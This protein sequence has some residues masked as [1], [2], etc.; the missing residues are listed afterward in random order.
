M[1]VVAARLVREFRI[2]LL[3]PVFSAPLGL[4]Y[5]GRMIYSDQRLP[6]FWRKRGLW[7][8]SC[9]S[10]FLG[11]IDSF[12]HS[13]AAILIQL[14]GLGLLILGIMDSSFLFMPLSND[15]L[16][17]AMTA[18]AHSL[19]PYYAAMASAGS[20]IGC[21]LVDLVF[22][23]GGE[24][25][26]QKHVSERRLAYVRDRVNKRAGWALLFATLMPP[27]FPFTPFIAVTAATEYPRKKMLTIVGAARMVRFSL[28][29]LLG[30]FFGAGIMSLIQST[31]FEYAV[32][33][34]I[35]VSIGGSIV[36]ILRWIRKSKREAPDTSRAQRR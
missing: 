18:R 17:I 10:A 28:E 3:G 16:V 27:P 21:L 29:G 20:V 15:L 25:M 6:E 13:A 7:G 23:K 9:L 12:L 30:I 22:R 24:G 5:A 26:L 19:L 31:E 35:V 14:G 36:Q 4:N 2:E 32:A 34:L 33:F 8:F 11:A 1:F